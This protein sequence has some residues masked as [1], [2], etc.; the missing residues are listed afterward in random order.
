MSHT[1]SKGIAHCH[2]ETME[3]WSAVS[4][5]RLEVSCHWSIKMILCSDFAVR[6][7][8]A[9]SACAF[10]RLS[11]IPSQGWV[12]FTNERFM[13]G[14]TQKQI[15]TAVKF[16]VEFCVVT[17]CSVVV[18][19]HCSCLQP[20]PEDGGSTA[21]RNVGILPQHYTASRRR[22]NRLECYPEMSDS[23]LTHEGVSRSFRT[24]RLERELQMVQLSATSS[25][26]IAILWVS[27][28]NFAAIIL[29]VAS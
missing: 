13:L 14:D 27:T 23:T 22:R 10:V 24:G 6:L 17:L 9:I 2:L 3:L 4:R 28:V 5:T 1:A 7:P 20:H 12:K 16:L 26:S 11:A 18:G 29:C 8:F 25:S 19:Y 21:L 15:L